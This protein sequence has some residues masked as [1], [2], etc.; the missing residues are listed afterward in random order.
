MLTTR[1]AG[2]WRGSARFRTGCTSRRS[3]PISRSGIASS[4]GRRR[5]PACS[6]CSD[7]SSASRSSAAEAV[8]AGGGHPVFRLDAVALHHRRRLRRVHA[9]VGVQRPA[10]MEPFAW[11]NA[12]GL[13]VER[14]VFTGGPVDL[15]Q[16]AAMDPAAWDR[17]LGGRAIKEVEFVR[18]QDEHYYVVRHAPA[19]PA[20]RTPR[21]A[22]PALQRHRTSGA[23]P[24]AG[25]GEHA[26]GPARAVQRRL[27]RRA[28][29]GRV[30]P[31][32]PIAGA[33]AAVRVRLVLLLPRPADA[34][35]RPAREVRRSRRR[36]GSTSIR[37]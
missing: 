13:E 28:A 21:A 5:S 11:T 18:I 25:G 7:W 29:Q 26:G 1:A 34:A 23:R 30:F 32:C 15:S 24:A 27:A 19:D 36:R 4:C 31:T 22:A 8:Q 20:G 6:P 37:R 3:A 10:S 17:L 16:F 33:A 9:D 12:T 2:R 14:D 35:A